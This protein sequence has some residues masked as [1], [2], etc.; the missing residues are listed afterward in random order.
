MR[1]HDR[2]GMAEWSKA[3]VS[4]TVVP[5][6]TVSSNLTSSAISFRQSRKEI[7]SHERAKASRMAFTHK[8]LHQKPIKSHQVT[9]PCKPPQPKS[10]PCRADPERVGDPLLEVVQDLVRFDHRVAGFANGVGQ[11]V[12]AFRLGNGPAIGRQAWAGNDLTGKVKG[13]KRQH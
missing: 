10:T 6:G 8:A 13:F 9:G 5:P 4:K 7:R 3:T 12:Q 1:A 2:G 11:V